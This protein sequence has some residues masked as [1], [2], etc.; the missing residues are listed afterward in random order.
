MHALATR[1]TTAHGMGYEITT[2]SS[3]KIS[4]SAYADVRKIERL[5]SSLSGQ[6]VRQPDRFSLLQHTAA[7]CGSRPTVFGQYLSSAN[8]HSRTI[9]PSSRRASGRHTLHQLHRAQKMR[10]PECSRDTFLTGGLW[11]FIPHFA[12]VH[13]LRRVFRERSSSRRSRN[14]AIVAMRFNQTVQPVPGE[15]SGS[16]CMLYSRRTRRW[17]RDAVDDGDFKYLDS[18]ER[19]ARREKE[20]SGCRTRYKDIQRRMSWVER[21][22]RG[23]R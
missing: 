14:T 1:R 20:L 17:F 21:A 5:F 4:A 19:E 9:D 13:G 11:H 3:S 8:D 2:T 18:E 10:S 12:G 16:S 6:F 23:K 22:T 7:R 15:R